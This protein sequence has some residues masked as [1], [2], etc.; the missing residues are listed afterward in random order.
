MAL[1]MWGEEDLS[2]NIRLKRTC[3]DYEEQGFKVAFF[4]K[5]V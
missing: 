5:H 3:D 2:L 4:F 1:I